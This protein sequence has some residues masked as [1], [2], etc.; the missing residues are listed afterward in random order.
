MRE[1]R[2][3]K[4]L[5]VLLL[6][7]ESYKTQ[8]KTKRIYTSE[9]YIFR[10]LFPKPVDCCSNG[11]YLFINFKDLPGS[12]S[13]FKVFLKMY[14]WAKV[15]LLEVFNTSHVSVFVDFD[16]CSDNHGQTATDLLQ[17]II[18]LKHLH[19]VIS[20]VSTCF[21]HGVQFILHSRELNWLHG[22]A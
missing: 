17:T 6:I 20:R 11:I 12:E 7:L 10:Y 21:G 3:L 2:S 9:E 8:S 4:I 16:L 22:I 1:F 14:I 15:R 18:W 13:N 19:L 5:W